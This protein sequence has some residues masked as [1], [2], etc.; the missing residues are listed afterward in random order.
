M[1][2]GRV[3][4]QRAPG[5]RD[6]APTPEPGFGFTSLLICEPGKLRCPK[7]GGI[8][9]RHEAISGELSLMC[10]G[11]LSPG[12]HC[13]AWLLV[14]YLGGDVALV[15]ASPSAAAK[16]ELVSSLRILRRR[17]GEPRGEL[18]T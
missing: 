10:E 3:D 15:I 5:Y 12:E 9:Y 6:A 14:V 18:E 4:G 1:T 2:A 8:V 13:R 17:V 7:C 11:R 16:E